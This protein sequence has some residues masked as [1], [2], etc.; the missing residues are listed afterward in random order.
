VKLGITPQKIRKNTSLLAKN[1]V[2]IE[3]IYQFLIKIGTSPSKINT[4]ETKD[5]FPL[6][7][8]IFNIA[9][10]KKFLSIK[11]NSI[12]KSKKKKNYF[13]DKSP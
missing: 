13:N 1:K 2:T 10:K 6:V 4:G 9:E 7:L 12:F 8:R 5:L 11:E 3:K